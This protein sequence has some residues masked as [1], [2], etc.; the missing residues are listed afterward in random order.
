MEKLV[1]AASQ[2]MGPPLLRHMHASHVQRR[3][4]VVMVERQLCDRRPL[5]QGLGVDQRQLVSAMGT[6]LLEFQ[7]PVL[8]SRF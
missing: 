4:D 1:K 5:R 3:G 2:S 7:Q 8:G 6:G